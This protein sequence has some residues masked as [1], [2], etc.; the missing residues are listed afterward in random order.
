VPQPNR[1]LG[2]LDARSQAL[3]PAAGQ[4]R[5]PA[6][7]RPPVATLVSAGA[8]ADAETSE[9]RRT[10]Y[11]S[12]V[13]RIAALRAHS[14]GELPHW[15]QH[16]TCVVSET[17]RQRANSRRELKAL[18]LTSSLT[19]IRAPFSRRYTAVSGASHAMATCSAVRCDCA[20]PTTPAGQSI[21]R[22]PSHAY[23]S[24]T[25]F[26]AFGS[27]PAPSSSTTTS[28]KLP[29]AAR[30]SGLRPACAHNTSRSGR[31]PSARGPSE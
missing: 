12:S 15:Q 26:W 6:P 16:A 28:V 25:E 10:L 13:W 4:V 11:G 8:A 7:S 1:P 31:A 9:K 24:R 3:A 21:R 23:V 17:A 27:A 18:L 20:A 19:S 14:I 30:C 29:A 5:L 22:W 2:R